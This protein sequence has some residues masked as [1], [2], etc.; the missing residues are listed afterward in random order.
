[1]AANP[2]KSE[3]ILKLYSRLKQSPCTIA[4]LEDWKEKNG[5]AFS[6]RSLYRYLDELAA[7]LKIKGESIEVYTGEYNKKTWKLVYN[8]S[9]HDFTLT[10]IHTFYLTR[11]FIPSDI[12]LQRRKSFQK[13]E[14]GFY[15][16]GSKGK[17]E[18]AAD[19]FNLKLQN[20]NFYEAH[21]TKAQQQ[22]IDQLIWAIQNKRKLVIESLSTHVDTHFNPV[23]TGHSILPLSLQQH[24]GVLHVC[25]YNENLKK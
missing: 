23:A 25:A 2:S 17:F 9:V 11:V 14:A 21:Y 4:I 3:I 16:K 19:T 6:S 12:L 24:R 5:F 1:M 13:M 8:K 22:T 15:E 10:D 7:N 20:S 18:F